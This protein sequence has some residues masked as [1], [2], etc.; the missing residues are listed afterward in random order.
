MGF[1]SDQGRGATYDPWGGV[2]REG[3]ASV[4][5]QNYFSLIRPFPRDNTVFV[6]MS[7]EETFES[8]WEDVIAPGIRSVQMKSVALEP[9]RVDARHISDSILTEILN[10]IST[11]GLVFADVT[12]LTSREGR[13]ERNGNVMY[14]V[15]LAHAVRLPEEVLLFRSDS[16]PIL[17]DIANVRVNRYDPDCDPE[18]ARIQVAKTIRESI[19]EVDLRRHLTVRRAAE[20]LDFK[21]WLMLL[22]AVGNGGIQ[23]FP[24]KT[25]R[26]ALGNGPNNEAIV[27]LLQ[28]GALEVN[29]Q[30]LA[31]ISVD[32]SERDAEDLRQFMKYRVTPLGKAIISYVT[33]E[34]TND[35]DPKIIKAMSDALAGHDRNPRP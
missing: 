9:R 18:G 4:F 35:C 5:P 32:D 12:A 19:K 7:F 21:S 15:G 3:D 6:A 26:E 27:R 2:P 30:T 8:R 16:H 13:V 29:Y 1:V 25:L 24:M 11:S 34:M 22:I 33:Q 23:Y 31:P 20:T 28:L 14:E 17:F 10:G